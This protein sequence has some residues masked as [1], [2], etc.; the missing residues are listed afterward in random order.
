MGI[1][2][3]KTISVTSSRKA[4]NVRLQ[5]IY[6]KPD[7]L[8]KTLIGPSDDSTRATLRDEDEVVRFLFV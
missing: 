7:M 1:N 8:V 3:N 6:K 2:T 5:G 4:F